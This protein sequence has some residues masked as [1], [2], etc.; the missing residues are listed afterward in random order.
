MDVPGD[1]TCRN[2][3]RPACPGPGLTPSRPV[4]A[5]PSRAGWQSWRSRP[6]APRRGCGVRG[7]APTPSGISSTRSKTPGTSWTPCTRSQSMVSWHQLW[8]SLLGA[9]VTPVLPSSAAC[10]MLLGCCSRHPLTAESWLRLR[11]SCRT[12]PQWDQPLYFC[13]A[14]IIEHVRDG[15]VVRALLL[16]DY[17][18]VTVMLS[19][20]KVRLG[21]QPRPLAG[22]LSTPLC[23]EFPLEFAPSFI[24][25]PP[26]RL[27][28]LVQVCGGC[29]GTCLLPRLPGSRGWGR[30]GWRQGYSCLVARCVILHA[31][32]S[33]RLVAA[34]GCVHADAGCHRGDGSRFG[35]GR[36]QC[37]AARP[38]SSPSSG[39]SDVLQGFPGRWVSGRPCSAA[40]GWHRGGCWCVDRRAWP[41]DMAGG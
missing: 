1:K 18:L 31:P 21:R 32:S 26:R 8:P 30:E 28:A 29:T 2:W 5:A 10:A 24:V 41:P 4:L 14:A 22:M 38:T 7:R 11:G 16:P 12:L 20:I 6:K 17:Y 36:Y 19:G 13:S 39:L 35:L 9:G 3:Q 23:S 40:M 25:H 27:L 37:H 34:R 15:S 33:N